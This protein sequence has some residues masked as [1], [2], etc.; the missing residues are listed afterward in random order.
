MEDRKK[1]SED[2]VDKIRQELKEFFS[3]DDFSSLDVTVVVT[4]SYGRNE[5]S[6][7]SDQGERMSV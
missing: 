5:A 1:Y 6:Q 2:I 3:K 4:G 7:A